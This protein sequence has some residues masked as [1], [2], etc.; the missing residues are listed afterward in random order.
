MER[1]THRPLPRSHRGPLFSARDRG[2]AYARQTLC[3][4]HISISVERNLAPRHTYA[5]R[6]RTRLT[7]AGF[8]IEQA[9]APLSS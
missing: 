2:V 8:N 7:R 4:H 5:A 9:Y 3:K 6:V 1:A